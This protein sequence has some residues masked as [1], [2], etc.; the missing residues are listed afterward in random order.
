LSKNKNPKAIRSGEKQWFTAR[1]SG[2]RFASVVRPM[3]NS[4]QASHDL[5]KRQNKESPP[6]VANG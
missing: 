4:R 3:R 1:V 2:V 5:S 6:V